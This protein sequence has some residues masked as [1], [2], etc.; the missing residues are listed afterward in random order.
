MTVQG[1]G[2]YRS[3]DAC[4]RC[5]QA[6]DTRTAAFAAEGMICRSC[7][8]RE[9]IRDAN[10][11]AIGSTMGLGPLGWGVVSLFCNVLFIPSILAITSGISDLRRLKEPGVRESL[12]DRQSSVHSKA[13][14]GIVL[15]F[16]H[17][18]LVV[19][20]VCLALVGGIVGAMNQPSYDSYDDSYLNDPYGNG[21]YDP[22]GG[23]GAYDPN[24]YG[25]PYGGTG[26]YDPNGYGND[27]YVPAA[28]PVYAP[29][30]YGG[31]GAYDPSAQ[32]AYAP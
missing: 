9:S 28:D 19:G 21:A 24:G 10:A 4:A 23:T 2:A 12:G 6:I 31:T 5:R 14:V 15:A 17:P 8:A 26:A 30:A 16:V 18:L 3:T 7:E 29:P 32:P 11:A 27:P 22:Y 20:I 25:S 1:A 13:V